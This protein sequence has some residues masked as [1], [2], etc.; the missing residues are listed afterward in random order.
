MFI[1]YTKKRMLD[2]EIQH[3]L[4]CIVFIKKFYRL[5][6]S[7]LKADIVA[8]DRAIEVLK[9]SINVAQVTG[10]AIIRSN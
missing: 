3:P 9:E 10:K 6:L 2:F 7:F 4:F 8:F 1:S 5:N